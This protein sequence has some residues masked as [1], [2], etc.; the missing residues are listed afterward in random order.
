M[1]KRKMD[2]WKIIFWFG[3]ISL[4][5]WLLAKTLGFINTPLIIE[6]IPLFSSL[7]ILFGGI[8]QI[9]K[10]IHRVENGLSNIIFLKEKIE[11][12]E[13][14]IEIIKF[15]VHSLNKKIVV[16]ESKI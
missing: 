14:K 7:A 4:F 9:A 13:N 16:L 1:K 2:I 6:L 12:I 10:F 15:D 11:N 5:L 3:V 8:K